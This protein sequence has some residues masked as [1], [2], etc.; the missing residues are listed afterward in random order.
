[1]SLNPEWK[2]ELVRSSD[3]VPINALDYGFSLSLV[4]NRPGS[5]SMTIP[6]DDQVAYEVAKHATAIRC[7]RNGLSKWSG[8]VITTPKNASGMTMGITALGWLDQL[9][10]RPVRA[11]EESALTFTAQTGGTIAQALMAAVNAQQDSGG[12]VRPTALTF[13]NKTDTQVRTRSYKRGQNYGQA[14]QELSDVEN[15]F[16]IRID[17]V[18]RTIST[19][20]P[21]DFEDRNGVIFGYNVEP[22]NLADITENDDGSNTAERV[23]A[24]GGNG[25]IVPADDVAA[26]TAHGGFMRDEWL[27]ISDVVDTT[28]IGAYANAELVY[29][30]YGT[31]TFDFQ[32]QPYADIP[33]LFDDFELGDKV[34]LS[35]DAGALQLDRQAVRIFSVTIEVDA[36]GNEIMSQIGTA[37][38]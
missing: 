26:I 12:T 35:A 19:Y 32:V 25:V 1:M 31:K 27:S 15:G 16:D 10:H 38:Q 6:L 9:N 23:T 29:R 33:R 18:D 11:N 24:V 4:F 7:T 21:T 2:I 34:Y 5:F 3:M 13:A 22:N 17:P 28:I 37:P 8:E 30:R 36:Q 20:P 14:I